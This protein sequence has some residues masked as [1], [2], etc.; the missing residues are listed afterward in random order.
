[1]Q[2]LLSIVQAA[3]NFPAHPSSPYPTQSPDGSERYIPFHLTFSDFQVSLP[4]LGLIRPV[5]LAEL[6]AEDEGEVR[7]PWQFYYTARSSHSAGKDKE[8]M[9][10]DEEGE[11]LDLEVQCVFFADWV[12][13][14]G[15]AKMGEVMQQTAEKWK[16]AGKFRKQL[17]GMSHFAPVSS[18]SFR[19]STDVLGWRNE[20][21]Q[22]YACPQSSYFASSGLQGI[23]ANKIFTLERAAC[24]LF[25]FA[26][27]GVHMMAYEGEG[28]DMKLWVPRRSKTKPTY[29]G[30][31][32]N[33]S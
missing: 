23:F 32:D 24:A 20:K 21:Y 33:V 28:K 16:A 25:G 30:M 3:D 1:M 2:S 13:Q 18:G 5:I 26:T 15:E 6:Q 10:V 11:E 4:P 17:D 19:I 14:A 7:S 27:F 9:E 22:I 8:A 29:P 31:L 12:I